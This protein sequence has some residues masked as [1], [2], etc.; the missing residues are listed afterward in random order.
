MNKT[1]KVKA[2]WKLTGFYFQS[3]STTQPGLLSV[4]GATAKKVA[5]SL[6]SSP[7]QSS[8]VVDKVKSQMRMMCHIPLPACWQQIWILEP[9]IDPYI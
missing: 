4:I 7:V 9:L 1:K 5:W 8:A 3:L 2:R 6:V